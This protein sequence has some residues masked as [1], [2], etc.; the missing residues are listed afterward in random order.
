[1]VTV[2]SFD[3][4]RKTDQT[5]NT[6]TGGCISLLSLISIAYLIYTQVLEYLAPVVSKDM[7][8]PSGIDP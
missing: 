3:Y 1:M 5:K 6:R 8:V 7:F 2:K 4:F